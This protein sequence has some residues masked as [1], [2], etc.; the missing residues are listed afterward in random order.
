LNIHGI[1]IIASSPVEVCSDESEERVNGGARVLGQLLISSGGKT[2][3]VFNFMPMMTT[4]GKA[5]AEP[6]E[7]GKLR[8]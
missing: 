2:L 3:Y 7:N 4:L 1:D 6:V 8:L 5:V